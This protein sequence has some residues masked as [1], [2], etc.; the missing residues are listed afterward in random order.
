M[1]FPWEKKKGEF[2][3]VC[4]KLMLGGVTIIAYTQVEKEYLL[5]GGFEL[6]L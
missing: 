1:R 3:Q 6:L 2:L 5:E 4:Y